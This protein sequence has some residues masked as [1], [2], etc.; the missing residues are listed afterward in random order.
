RSAIFSGAA[1]AKGDR[2]LATRTAMAVVG[3]SCSVAVDRM[4]KYG[5]ASYR[6]IV[7]PFE[8][9]RDSGC[10]GSHTSATDPRAS[11]RGFCPGLVRRTDWPVIFGLDNG[12]C[13]QFASR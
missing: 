5:P 8:R 2:R 9:G 1:A 7:T 4:R 12:S 11:H 13:H 3:G 6:P 10:V